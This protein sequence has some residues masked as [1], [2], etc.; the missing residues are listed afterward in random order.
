MKNS[1][2]D[3]TQTWNTLLKE[4]EKPVNK[5]LY[6]L[7]LIEQTNLTEKLNIGM[8]FAI[9]KNINEFITD[10]FLYEVIKNPTTEVK[11]GYDTKAKEEYDV[12]HHTIKKLFDLSSIDG[13]FVFENNQYTLHA[14]NHDNKKIIKSV[15]DKS[16][17]EALNKI[18]EIKRKNKELNP[19]NKEK[20]CKIVKKFG[21]HYLP[22]QDEGKEKIK[23][24]VS[25]ISTK[26]F[27]ISCYISRAKISE[28]I[29][30]S[31]HLYN[32]D[33]SRWEV[34]KFLVFTYLTMR[35][36]PLYVKDSLWGNSRR[37]EIIEGFCQA[38]Q[39][40]LVYRFFNHISNIKHANEGL[41]QLKLN[42]LTFSKTNL[43]CIGGAITYSGKKISNFD[44][45]ENLF[46]SATEN[47]IKMFIVFPFK[48]ARPLLPKEAQDNITSFLNSITL[49]D[50][51]KKYILYFTS[52][53]I[54]ELSTLIATTSK[55]I[56]PE[57]K[58]EVDQK[59][60]QEKKETTSYPLKS[61]IPQKSV[62]KNPTKLTPN[63]LTKKPMTNKFELQVRGNTRKTE[64]ELKATKN[65]TQQTQHKYTTV[66]FNP[67]STET[68]KEDASTPEIKETDPTD[69]N[70]EMSNLNNN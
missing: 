29:V 21:G 16:D 22:K 42:M 8:C 28:S 10:G 55:I 40:G 68:R 31:S 9:L 15:T 4:I 66:L 63:S 25:Y 34:I 37:K 53:K 35:N 46:I 67:K 5:H 44:K 62:D 45:E 47:F 59:K 3:S 70:I 69:I 65:V 39:A 57:I 11:E 23:K 32:I 1:P 61:P 13:Y 17:I 30:A 27:D 33:E 36:N 49:Q 48:Q 24:A 7:N 6:S 64:P 52:I 12:I 60:H 50:V 51:D 43:F 41:K 2:L 56:K 19:D 14:R 38:Y 58:K 26:R 20:L 54:S 18:T